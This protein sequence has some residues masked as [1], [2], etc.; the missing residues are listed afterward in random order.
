M[1]DQFSGRAKFNPLDNARYAGLS[2]TSV[3]DHPPV[4]HRRKDEAIKTRSHPR[5]LK[6]R[7]R[8]GSNIELD[9]RRRVAKC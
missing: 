4:L 1:R 2:W 7:H 8:S 6:E 9:A 5:P 3:H